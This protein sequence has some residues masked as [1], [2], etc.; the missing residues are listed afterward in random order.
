[1]T[2]KRKSTRKC[3]RKSTKK[4]NRKTTKRR[5]LSYGNPYGLDNVKTM[6]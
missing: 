4:T 5:D 1:M 2:V 6:M 3:T